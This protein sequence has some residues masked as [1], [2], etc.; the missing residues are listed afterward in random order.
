MIELPQL[1][2]RIRQPH[3]AFRSINR[4][5][6]YK[7]NGTDYN[8]GG[9]DF[10]E[11]NW[12]NLLLLDACR[13]DLF[14]ETNTIEGRL[15]SRESRGADTVEFLKGNF[16]GKVFHDTVYVTASPMLYR[17]HDHIDV[18]FHDVIDIWNSGGWDEEA[19]TVLPEP[20]TEAAMEAAE[21]YPNKR[22]FVHYLQPHYPFIGAK[23]RPFREADA[24]M[25][26]GDRGSWTRAAIGE[27]DVTRDEVWS[28][29][30]ANLEYVLDSVAELVEV[31]N[32]KTV[33]TSDHGNLLGE[34]AFPIP[35]REWG[36]PRGLHVHD[37]VTVP[38]LVIEGEERREIV[39]EEPE[40][41]ADVDADDSTVRERLAQLGYVDAD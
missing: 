6:S 19:K 20:V 33:V 38:W 34:R 40:T 8:T 13:Y 9:V 7:Q 30:R 25:K 17:H 41:R 39:A 12:D 32:G 37:L 14:K 23:T 3:L 21:R 11:E 22:L 5:Y 15:E 2:K 1:V 4:R 35:I 27:I 29:Y 26:Q 24:F 16:R 28:A 18:E 10:F 36:H 31:L